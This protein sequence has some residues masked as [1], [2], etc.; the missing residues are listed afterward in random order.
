M[1]KRIR[2]QNQLCCNASISI[3]SFW[4]GITIIPQLLRHG[5]SHLY[6]FAMLQGENDE[7]TLEELQHH[8]FDHQW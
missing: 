3:K 2:R 1:K 5:V 4:N 8:Y 7:A 6:H